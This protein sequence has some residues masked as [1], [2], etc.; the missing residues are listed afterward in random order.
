M[1]KRKLQWI[2]KY[3]YISLIMPLS[4]IYPRATNTNDKFRDKFHRIIFITH[5][6]LI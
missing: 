1:Y 6:Y 5:I 2:M 3:V 4:A